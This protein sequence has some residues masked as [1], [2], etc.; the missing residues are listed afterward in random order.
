[1]RRERIVTDNP[2]ERHFGYARAVRAGSFVAISGTVA[3]GSDGRAVGAGAYE[4][5]TEILRRIERTLER[6]D[7]AL[8]DV[9][10]LRVYFADA[11]V[12]DGFTRALGEAFPS[13]APALTAVRVAALVAPEFLLEIEAEAIV[14]G[15]PAGERPIA[16]TPDDDV[17]TA[18]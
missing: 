17:E 9:V 16:R 7:G 15:G 12:A 14:A 18:D 5:T 3:A 6:A 11:S 10:R 8:S 1:M 4:Q 2:W 13:G